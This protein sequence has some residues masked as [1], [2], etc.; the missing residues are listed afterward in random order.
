MGNDI[1]FVVSVVVSVYV[2]TRIVGV[3][4]GAFDDQDEQ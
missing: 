4:L 1:V 3:T 2:I